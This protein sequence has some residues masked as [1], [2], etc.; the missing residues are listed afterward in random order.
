MAEIE[1]IQIEESGAPETLAI[2]I[3]EGSPADSDAIVAFIEKQTGRSPDP[4]YI[5]RL[6]DAYPSYHAATKEGEIIAAVYSRGHAPDLLEVVSLF[7]ASKYRDKGI[8]SMLLRRIEEAGSSWKNLFLSNSMLWP[9]E[10]GEKQS[11]VP[12][13][14]ERGWEVMF[15]TGKT[16]ILTKAVE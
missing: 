5:R 7:V 6:L 4:S 9:L 1:T 11:A 8:G 12:F 2:V 14:E 16:A 15:D 3:S 13:F 10:D